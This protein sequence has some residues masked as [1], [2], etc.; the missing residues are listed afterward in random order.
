LEGGAERRDLED[1]EKTGDQNEMSHMVDLTRERG[2]GRN[3]KRVSVKNNEGKDRRRE[4]RLRIGFPI[5]PQWWL[6][7]RP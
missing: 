3:K 7:G 4:Y 2:E 6:W 5:S 1:I